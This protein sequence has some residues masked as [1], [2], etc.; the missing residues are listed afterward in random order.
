MHKKQ[1]TITKS[2]SINKPA[3]QEKDN[4]SWINTMSLQ[5][6]GETVNKYLENFGYFM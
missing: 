1:H 3:S 6:C 4:T 2:V 5:Q